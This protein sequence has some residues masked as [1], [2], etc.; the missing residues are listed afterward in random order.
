MYQLS[1]QVAEVP[2]G[3]KGFTSFQAELIKGLVLGIV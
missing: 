1:D 3:F 2:V